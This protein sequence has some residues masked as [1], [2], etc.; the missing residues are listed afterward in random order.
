MTFESTS[1]RGASSR[2]FTE[3][4][5]PPEGPGSRLGAYYS[6]FQE[7]VQRCLPIQSPGGGGPPSQVVRSFVLG[8]SSPP[9]LPG[10]PAGISF[11]HYFCTLPL[12][13]DTIDH[14]CTSCCPVR[15][16]GCCGSC[17]CFCF[18]GGCGCGFCFCGW[19]C[20]WGCT[21]GSSFFGGCGFC[22]AS[23]VVVIRSS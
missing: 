13:Y 22:R 15:C 11:Q 14:V 16:C 4:F 19:W 1:P 17:S 6:P 2:I 3:R 21:S 7:C 9:G 20:G 18:C 23:A 5:L 8:L 12:Q 10:A